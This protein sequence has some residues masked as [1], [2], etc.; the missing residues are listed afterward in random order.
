MPK[1]W[2]QEGRKDML[3][4]STT[5]ISVVK[6]K[7]D[8]LYDPRVEQ[9]DPK[10]N[11]EDEALV[12][13]VMEDGIIEPVVITPRDPKPAV[14]AGRRRYFAAEEASRRQKAAGGEEVL[15]P[16]IWYRGDETA[17]LGVTMA[18]N[19]H[20]KGVEV[21]QSAELARRYINQGRTVEQAARKLGFSTT[22]LSSLLNLDAAKPAVKEAVKKDKVAPA[23]G[24]DIAKAPHHKQEALLENRIKSGQTHGADGLHA[25]KAA[26]QGK[27]N[28]AE[29]VFN[30]MSKSYLAKLRDQLEK[31]GLTIDGGELL[32]FLL[33]NVELK[34]IK[35]GDLA[36]AIKASLK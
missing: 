21:I 33:G 26:R 12:I 25:S 22:Y 32:D 13:S 34:K 15:V 8:A 6:D 4:F 5:K 10:N 35:D 20:R 36:D 11:P 28:G 9:W 2:G 27:A 18:E 30:P 31:K 19:H 3:T 14:V 23:V 7:G 17:L 24:M 16:C 1:D 29:K